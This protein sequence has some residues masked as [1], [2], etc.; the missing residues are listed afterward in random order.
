M[1]IK[2]AILQSHFLGCLVT[3]SSKNCNMKIAEVIF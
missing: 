3:M 1:N 2:I